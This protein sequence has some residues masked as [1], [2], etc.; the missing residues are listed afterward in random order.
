MVLFAFVVVSCGQSQADKETD[1]QWKSFTSPA[2][3][4]YELKGH[5]GT[6]I[7]DFYASNQN[8]M[9]INKIKSDTIK[10]DVDGVCLSEILIPQLWVH[11]G[12]RTL[13]YAEDGNIQSA[14][15]HE[16]FWYSGAS[17]RCKMTYENGMM[18][19]I[20]SKLNKDYR[21]YLGIDISYNDNKW[22]DKAVCV[23]YDMY[24][25]CL[26]RD[27]TI[28]NTYNKVDDN[29]NWTECFQKIDENSDKMYYLITRTITM[30]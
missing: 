10:F 3:T 23:E 19:K 17:A 16:S 24:D 22:I 7:Y 18:V 8:G 25:V 29:G 15:A 5:V 30:L 21:S 12:S 13:S 11:F 1:E 6:V 4:L 28:N 20:T 27:Y 14:T 9:K 26:R 2:L